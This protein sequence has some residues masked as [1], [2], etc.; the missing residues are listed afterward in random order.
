MFFFSAIGAIQMRY[1]DDDDDDIYFATGK[2]YFN[3]TTFVAKGHSIAAN[4]Q[5]ST[6]NKV[7]VTRIGQCKMI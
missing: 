1:D 6:E 7:S 4:K 5:N 2:I 3:V